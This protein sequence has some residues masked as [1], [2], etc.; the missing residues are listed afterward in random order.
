MSIRVV[1]LDRLELR[2]EPRPWSFAQARRGE[3]DAHFAR[4]RRANP[5]LWNGN[6]LLLHR[7]ELAG[8]VFRGAYLE[9][10]FASF[11]T[12]RDW[13]WPDR[14]VNNCFGLGA[15]R[16]ADGPFLLGVMGAHTANA[17]KIYFP[18]GTPD[19]LDIVDG[20]VDLDVSIARELTEETGLSPQ[21]ATAQS[22]WHAVFEGPRI[23]MIKVLQSRLPASELRARILAHLAREAQPELADIRVVRGPDDFDPMMPPFIP[24]FL[25]HVWAAR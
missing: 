24:A 4:L 13:D 14:T 5:T 20:R 19:P 10:D 22:V 11:I 2:F 15:L 12:W 1:R 16:A 25:T 23:A 6:V 9:T 3:I 21:D 7:F 17:G 18:G 8:Q